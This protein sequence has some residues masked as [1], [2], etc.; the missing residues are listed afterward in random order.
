MP[1]SEKSH[2]VEAHKIER[3]AEVDTVLGHRRDRRRRVARRAADAGV[4]E[5][6][7]LTLARQPVRHQ[8]VPVVQGRGEV[9]EQQQREVSRP[10]EAPIGEPDA[11]GLNEFGGSRF[12]RSIG[13]EDILLDYCA[14]IVLY[15]GA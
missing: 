9:V 1:P 3:P 15:S 10:A 8:G 13:H 4:V 11:S 2:D 14:A 5:Q 6:D 12:M 7:D